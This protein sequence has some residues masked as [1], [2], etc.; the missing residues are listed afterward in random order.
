[1]LVLLVVGHGGIG[2]LG[3]KKEG[4]ERASGRSL[5]IENGRKKGLSAV[6]LSKTAATIK[7]PSPHRPWDT[8]PGIPDRPARPASIW[9]PRPGDCRRRAP[10]SASC[11]R[12]LWGK[13]AEDAMAA[14]YD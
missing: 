8:Y 14:K 1:M 9:R 12:R 11:A 10:A 7:F 13:A 4:G 5:E 2:W 6:R 3:V